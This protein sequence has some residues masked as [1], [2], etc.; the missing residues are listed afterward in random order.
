MSCFFSCYI[1]FVSRYS[2]RITEIFKFVSDI[3]YLI[4]LSDQSADSQRN[5]ILTKIPS[6][7]SRNKDNVYRGL[8]YIF[9]F[10]LQ[11]KAMLLSRDFVTR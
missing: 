8:F 2:N 3:T 5:S 1:A 11:I 10:G 6:R 9:H 4:R 7:F